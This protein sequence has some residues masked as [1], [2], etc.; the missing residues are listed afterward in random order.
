MQSFTF[1][2]LS[3]FNVFFVP[4]RALSL[5]QLYLTNLLDFIFWRVLLMIFVLLCFPFLIPVLKLCV[6]FLLQNLV[7]SLSF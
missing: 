4:V 1:T 3:M 5:Q 6:D 7:H 2:I